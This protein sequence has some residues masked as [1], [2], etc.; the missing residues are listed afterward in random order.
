MYLLAEIFPFFR[1]RRLPFSRD[2]VMLLMAAVNE[3]F[4]GLDT[5][6]AHVLNGTIQPREW[7]PIIFGVTAGVILLLAGLI[8]ARNRPLASSL[9]TLVFLA[10]IFVGVIGAYF[11]WLRG[12]VNL[13]P[14]GSGLYVQFMIWAPPIFAPF[15]FALVGVLGISAAWVENPPDS[16][17]LELP[18]GRV[19]TLPYSKTR[20]YCFMVAMGIIVALTSSTLDHVRHPWETP[21]LWSPVV[22][23][24]F[25]LVVTAGLGIIQTPTRFD[26]WTY[27]SAMLLLM[28]VGLIGGFFHLNA[29]LTTSGVIV[30][31]RFLRG[32]P[33]LAPLL[34][35]NM[36]LL[37]LVVLLDPREAAVS[38]S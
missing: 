21:W 14:P 38:A 12:G 18:F 22:I 26:I 37:G 34:Y 25:A 8:A 15:A 19:L 9:A 16:G 29:S 33:I 10:S 2:Q 11:H 7:I 35:T 3:F 36:G 23:G 5:Y 1:R 13:V 32:A 27:L 20:A 28:L 24:I 4:L 30:P 17:S 31:E 6:L